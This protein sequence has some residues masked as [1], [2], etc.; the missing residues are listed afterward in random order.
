[1]LL[2]LMTTATLSAHNGDLK[3]EHISLEHGLSQSNITSIVQDQTGF[4]WFGTLDGLNKYDGY[5]FT[6]YKHSADDSSTL[7]SSSIWAIYEDRLGYI[8]VA[9]IS[10]GLNRFDPGTGQFIRFKHDASDP[11]SLSDNR[12]R[13]I[14]EDAAG[15]LWIGT[16]DQG[17]NRFDRETAAFSHFRHDPEDETSI[18]HNHIRSMLLDRD[19]TLWVGTFAGGLNRLQ[20]SS[21]GEV[22]FKRYLH[23]DGD[24]S[25]LSHN[26]VEALFQDRFGT[27]WVGT[28]GGGLNRLVDES[29]GDNNGRAAITFVRYRADGKPGSLSYDVV[30]TIVEDHVGTLWVGTNAGGLNVFDR[31]AGR[32]V[33]HRNDPRD[34]NSLSHDNV[35]TMFEDRTGNLWV[36]TWGGGIDKLDRKPRKFLHYR[37][38][39]MDENS[40]CHRDVR[41]ICE[42]PHGDLW[43]GTAG[44]GLDRINRQTGNVTHYR[45]DETDPASL[46]SNN[47][48]A[49]CL[50]RTGTLW[51][52]TYGGGLNELVSSSDPEIASLQFRR[53]GNAHGLNEFIWIVYEDSKGLIWVGTN[54][55][56]SRL[57][58]ETGAF[59]HFRHDPDDPA[60]LSHPIVRCIYQDLEGRIWVG[61]YVGLN[62]LDQE[63]GT[64]KRYTHEPGNSNSLSNNGVMAMYQDQPGV[65]WL[66]TLGGGLNHFDPEAQQ[67]GH[68]SEQD[69]LPNDFVHAILNDSTGALWMSTNGG[70]TRLD[71]ENRTFR[72]YDVTDGLQSNEFNVGTAHKS[73]TGELFFGGVNGL[74]AFH[75]DRIRDNPHIPEIVITGFK[76]FNRPVKFEKSLAWLEQID[77]SYRQR[78]FSFEFAALDYTNPSKNRYAYKMEGFDSEW[79][80]S[81][82]RRFA[83]YTNLD[84][85][86]YVFRVKGSNNDGIWNEQGTAITI[87]IEPPFWQTWWFRILAGVSVIGMLGLLYHRRVSNLGKAKKAQEQYATRLIE[88]QEEERKRIASELHDSLG[89]EL[90]IINNAIQQLVNERNYDQALRK[91]LGQLSEITV[92]SIDL[93]REISS[94]LHPHQIE[95]L[96]L[97]KAVEAMIEKLSSSTDIAFQADIEEIGKPLDKD[98]QLNVYRIIQEGLNN[99]VKHAGATQV[100]IQL[101]ESNDELHIHIRDNGKGFDATAIAGSGADSPGFGLMNMK[102]RVRMRKGKIS[103]D[104]SHAQGTAISI[105]LPVRPEAT[106]ANS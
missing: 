52:G 90:L 44:G 65:L 27:I 16:R 1:M 99:I 93:V 57:H 11:H 5:D 7:S 24:D 33:H 82:D 21:S 37:H 58:P 8:W 76:V 94:N 87:T 53:Y 54:N 48:R 73:E 78:F 18:S 74:T 34:A 46:S 12:V 85:G 59:I 84:P 45:H 75:P 101:R 89:Q 13:A 91:E 25:S 49:L 80:K 60:S 32:F 72:N 64:F 79:I 83:S 22:H 56:L 39:P 20:V 104:S 63:T 103:V 42:G 51:A 68:Y 70:L 15:Q 47:V 81:G 23:D 35:E 4:L 92:Q 17:L 9:T 77:L 6:V 50:D 106:G 100:K 88:V 62:L 36:G 3:F 102:E 105:S 86:H 43:V 71:R 41:A 2:A 96:G 40:L 66:G 38:K 61:T 26:H 55:G 67:F 31:E 69:G 10:A 14:H 29:H 97:K 30:E 19:G 98:Q 28:Y 95:R